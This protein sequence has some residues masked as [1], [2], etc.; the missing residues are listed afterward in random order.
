MEAYRELNTMKGRFGESKYYFGACWWHLPAVVVLVKCEGQWV[1]LQT[2][3]HADGP[4]GG[5][6]GSARVAGVGG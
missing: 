5:H 4:S 3:D 1:G 2:A 6:C